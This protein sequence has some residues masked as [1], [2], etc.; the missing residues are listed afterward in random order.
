MT[1][2]ILVGSVFAGHELG[3]RLA[4]PDPHVRAHELGA[5]GHDYFAYAKCFVAAAIA[6]LIVALILRARRVLH[7]RGAERPP[8]VAAVLL[9]PLAFLILETYERLSLA[10]ITPGALISREVGYG[11]LLQ[12]PFA[13]FALIV[14]RLLVSAAD[15]VGELLRAAPF[16]PRSEW[17]LPIVRPAE[18]ELPRVPIAALAYGLR[19]PPA[20]TA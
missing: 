17:R 1:V 15:A 12:I 9:A 14:V 10:E 2:P 8:A 19:G 4:F 13:V 7:G 6:V 20:S 11:L 16:V 3:Y 5:T 18:A